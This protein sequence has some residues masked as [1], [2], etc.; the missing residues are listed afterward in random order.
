VTVLAVEEASR[1]V[2]E[3]LAP[4]MVTTFYT[5]SAVAIFAFLLGFAL[6]I[7][8]YFKGRGP[9]GVDHPLR[10]FRYAAAVVAS[11]STV[12]SRDLTTRLAHLAIMWGFIALFIGTVIVTI[13]YDFARNI[14]PGLR[15]WNG[16]FYLGF[17]L[18][19]DTFGA[20]FLVGLGTM[21]V[22]RWVITPWRLRYDRVDKAV[23]TYDRTPYRRGDILFVSLLFSIGFT[24]F[25][26]EGFRLAADRPDSAIYSPLGSTIARGLDAITP[27]HMVW[28]GW[29]TGMWWFHAALALSFIAYIPY[30]KAI[31]IFA[32]PLNLFLRDPMAGRRLPRPAAMRT[33]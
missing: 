17:K 21:M 16:G 13:D 6:R 20:L 8:K 25:L 14:N 32:D 31:H 7:R 30:S 19:L 26:L 3:N 27:S 10:R 18:T 33:P 11:N 22:R 12:G 24:G 15:F 23:G 29:H 28:I 2:F 9:V 4:W 5:V 1:P